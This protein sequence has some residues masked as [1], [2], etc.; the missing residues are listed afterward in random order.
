M[1]QDPYIILEINLNAS[2]EDVRKAY[3]MAIRLCPPEKNTL[4]FQRI[5]VAYDSIKTKRQRIEHN[6]FNSVIPSPEDIMAQA[7]S[8]QSS[9]TK[10][11]PSLKTLQALLCPPLNKKMSPC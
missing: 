8:F 7:A 10:Q 9:S 11:R 2:D 1:L 6:L 5:Q 4:A 3:L